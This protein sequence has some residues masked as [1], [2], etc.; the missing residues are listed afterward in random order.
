MINDCILIFKPSVSLIESFE[1]IDAVPW[2]KRARIQEE[3]FAETNMYSMK[4]HKGEI[5]LQLKLMEILDVWR[6]F[7]FYLQCYGPSHSPA[8]SEWHT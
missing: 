2:K 6:L 7:K 1:S 8:P 5:Q 3:Q 4:P